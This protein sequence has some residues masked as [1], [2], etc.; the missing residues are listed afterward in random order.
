MKHLLFAA[1]WLC[2][3]TIYA[4]LPTLIPR[5]ILF[6][7]PERTDPQI[8]PGG[9]QLTWLAPD[10]NGVLNVWVSAMGRRESAFGHQRNRPSYSLLQMASRRE[11]YPLSP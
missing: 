6:G 2:T 7:N 4:E 11:T 5:E 8:S 10:K 3:F 9:S 1:I